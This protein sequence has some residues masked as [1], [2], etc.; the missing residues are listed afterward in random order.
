MKFFNEQAVG[1]SYFVVEALRP[2]R[3]PQR[4]PDD[5]YVH[6]A[7]MPSRCGR[8]AGSGVRRT[9]LRKANVRKASG[10]GEKAKRLTLFARPSRETAS[11]ARRAPR[12]C[13]Q[14]SPPTRSACIPPAPSA[15]AGPRTRAAPGR[16][17][18][19]RGR[20]QSSGRCNRGARCTRRKPQ[21]GVTSITQ[22]FD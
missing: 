15:S 4:K 7:F 3:T 5:F 12:Q 14:L 19:D 16:A 2:A 20:A 17:P 18:S 8:R 1:Q 22:M 10:R 11:H 9:A 13:F 6:C 21:R